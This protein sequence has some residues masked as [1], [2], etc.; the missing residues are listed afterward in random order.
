MTRWQAAR[1]VVAVGWPMVVL[2]TVVG[3]D[4]DTPGINPAPP[5]SAGGGGTPDGGAEAAADGA[6]GGEAG[7][8]GGGEEGGAVVREV[9]FRNPFGR[10]DPANMLHDGDFELSALDT[11][12]YPWL[13]IEQSYLRTGAV[14][15]SG[16]RCVEM[17]A[18]HYIL[19]VFVWPDA[20]R[21]KVTFYGKPLGSQDCETEGVG[22]V[23]L[24][25]QQGGP[26]TR[27]GPA[28]P[29]PVDGWCR[30]ER[31]IPVPQDPGY[32]F[33]G[34]LVATR[35][36][37]SESVVFDDA[38]MIGTQEETM[39]PRAAVRW[40]AADVAMLEEARD[41]AWQWLPPN[42]QDRPSPVR[43]PTG[44]RGK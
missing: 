42:P 2:G 34:L 1:A 26:E 19:G 36:A 39:S 23:L 3:C 6:S 27:I 29:E 30:Y 17:P 40:T 18:G 13:G 31:I 38:S 44:R 33:W 14:C 37:A 35:S 9:L 5:C 25:D 12:Q 32:H 4:A 43:N 22:L 28:T 8:E 24:L 15:R 20:P 41:R 7:P 21:V 10:L 16:L 11:L